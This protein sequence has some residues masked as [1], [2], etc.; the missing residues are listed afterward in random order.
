MKIEIFK[1][2]PEKWNEY[3]MKNKGGNIYHQYAWGTFLKEFYGFMPL[4]LAA[5]DGD[6]IIG[7]APLVSMK[8]HSMKRIMVSLPFFC[9]G[10]ILADSSQIEN[11]I[12]QKIKELTLDGNYN[13][14]L[15]RSEHISDASDYYYVDEQKSTFVLPLNADPEKVFSG[16]QKQV[17]RRIRKAYKSGCFVD[18]SNKY[19]DDFYDIYRT[20]MRLLGSPVHS[21]K[22]YKEVMERFPNNYTVLA[23]LLDNKVIGGQFLSYFKK[24]VYLPLASSLKEYNKYSP[25]HLLYWESIKYGCENGYEICDFGR[26]TIESGPYIFKKQWNAEEIPLKYCYFYAQSHTTNGS[27]SYGKLKLISEMWKRMPLVVSV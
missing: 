1:E 27:G 9:I 24:T 23:V 10:G 16:F 25:T 26:S 15:I 21:K 22:F 3:V 5:Y 14:S 2:S 8:N 12:A 11:L 7:I 19:F 13:Y 18:I 6:S 17:R 4:Y 20:N